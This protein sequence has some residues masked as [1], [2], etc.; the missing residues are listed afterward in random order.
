MSAS[1]PRQPDTTEGRAQCPS[2]SLDEA[3]IILWRCT[4]VNEDFDGHL[5]IGNAGNRSIEGGE[6]DLADG[7]IILIRQSE[8]EPEVHQIAL[9]GGYGDIDEKVTRLARSP[10]VIDFFAGTSTVRHAPNNAQEEE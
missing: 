7:R 2:R 5:R 3:K 10:E 4:T 6:Y 9:E 8:G 1:A